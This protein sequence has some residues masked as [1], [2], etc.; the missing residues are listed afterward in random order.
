MN[1]FERWKDRNSKRMEAQSNL[2]NH[3]IFKGYPSIKISN[4]KIVGNQPVVTEYQAAVVSQQEKDKAYIYTQLS[5]VLTLGSIWSAKTLHWL[6]AE[7]IITIKDVNWH[8]YMSYLCNINV[9]NTWGYFKGPEKNYVNIKNESGASLESLQK[10]VLVLPENI[11]GFKDKIVI[12]NRPWLV[13]EWDAISSP[14]LVYYSLRATTISKEVADQHIGEDI[15]ISRND[16]EITPIIIEPEQKTG[17]EDLE[18][19]IGNEIDFTLTT[20]EGYFR[21]NKKVDIKKHTATEITFSIPFGVD[22]VTVQTKKDG[23]VVVQ[24][25][26]TGE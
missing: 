25:F 18:Y 12:K 5:D 9:E 1:S 16:S 26:V 6:I 11:L 21:T 2:N 14:G 17:S 19:R 8:K 10:P 15:Y 4:T 3:F 13:Q 22:K 20:E 24:H 23:H 7:E